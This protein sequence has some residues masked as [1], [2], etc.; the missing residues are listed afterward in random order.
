MEAIPSINDYY[1]TTGFGLSLETAPYLVERQDAS[2]LADLNNVAGT[3]TGNNAADLAQLQQSGNMSSRQYDAYVYSLNR[4]DTGCNRR[5]ALP[6]PLANND[7]CLP[8]WNCECSTLL[9]TGHEQRADS[10]V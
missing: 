3:G 2:D 10:E 7:T 9:L 4:S 6:V 8:G 1:D 5:G